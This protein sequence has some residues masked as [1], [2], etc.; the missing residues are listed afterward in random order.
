[1]KRNATRLT[2]LNLATLGFIAAYLAYDWWAITY[3]I[4]Q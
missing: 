2:V 1:M 3:L 4:S